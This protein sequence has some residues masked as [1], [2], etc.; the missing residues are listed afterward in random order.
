MSEK[1]SIKS[2]LVVIFL[3]SLLI[4]AGY[5]LWG[6]LQREVD[7][8]K[9]TI[10]SIVQ[11]GPEKRALPT[12]Y[13]AELMDLSVDK[14]Q[15]LFTFD[16]ALAEEALLRSP[17]ITSAKVKKMRP[18]IIYVDYEIRHPIAVLSDYE[19]IGIDSK[20]YLFPLTPFFLSSSLPAFYLGIKK[21]APF[22]WA[23]PL[24]TSHLKLAFLIFQTLDSK[25]FRKLFEIK[26][27]DV[28]KAFH[29]SYGRREVV[30]RLEEEMK[31]GEARCR[32]S[33]VLRL[34]PKEYEKE[35]IHFL[36]L[37]EKMKTDYRIQLE[38]RKVSS[39]LI[40]FEPKVIDFRVADLAFIKEG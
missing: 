39:D 7:G 24:Q 2:S 6:Y 32:F 27:I 20:G 16:I 38:K 25:E 36:S 34:T 17:L 21:D 8:K 40:V 10:L 1:Q 29:P 30:I 31:L 23:E 4:V 37:H 3:P 13:L 12:E 5:F 18:G 22:S 11:T 14:P 28:S 35:L 19:N 33:E 15:D 9:F 26:N